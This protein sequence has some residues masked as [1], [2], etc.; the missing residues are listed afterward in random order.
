[1]TTSV[2]ARL[3]LGAF[4]FALL[5][6]ITLVSVLLG[7]NAFNPVIS[8]AI[9][10]SMVPFFIW[11]RPCTLK[12]FI[13]YFFPVALIL[14]GVLANYVKNM[15]QLGGISNNI[16]TIFPFFYALTFSYYIGTHKKLL[17]RILELYVIAITLFSALAIVDLLAINLGLYAAE[18]IAGSGE[19]YGGGDQYGKGLFAFYG[20]LSDG[21]IYPR[22]Y[23]L[24]P[25]PGHYAMYL[26][27][28]LIHNIITRKPAF[29][30]INFI[31]FIATQSFGG[32]LALFFILATMLAYSSSQKLRLRHFIWLIGIILSFY[33][34]YSYLVDYLVDYYIAK[35]ESASIRVNN[36][37][38][39]F[40]DFKE[41]VYHYPLGYPFF[42]SLEQMRLEERFVVST[43]FS[44]FNIY[45]QGGLISLIGY[46]SLVFICLY[47]A[48]INH[49]KKDVCIRVFCIVVPAFI[50]FTVQR[51]TPFETYYFP[52]LI[53]PFIVYFSSGS[54]YV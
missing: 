26:L 47:Y 33:F 21:N 28:V 29:L 2:S 20:I 3:C 51:T 39:F 8:I 49:R 1:M 45:I 11:R 37:L 6:N 27:P 22:L 7:I 10:A 25:E 13:T 31:C 53:A 54:D 24:F 16:A 34:L 35:G 52:F 15:V 44:P 32:Y 46:V 18:P 42:E 14:I 50:L 5:C 19:A 41:M 12:V 4:W 43:N 48:L 9:L 30:A 17:D 23:G 38:F 40:K 36:V